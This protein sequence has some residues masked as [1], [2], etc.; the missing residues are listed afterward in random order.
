M[1]KASYRTKRKKRKKKTK[2]N[3]KEV[4]D[5]FRLIKLACKNFGKPIYLMRHL[6][7]DANIISDSIIGKTYNKLRGKKGGSLKHYLPYVPLHKEPS[8]TVWGRKDVMLLPKKYGVT[9]NK[10]DHYT[11]IVS[12]LLRTWIS[13]LLF[14]RALVKEKAFTLT[15]IISPIIEKQG[16]GGNTPLRQSYQRFF[17]EEVRELLEEVTIKFCDNINRKLYTCTLKDVVT[18]GATSN[19]ILIT[20]LY[21]KINKN[22]YY[23]SFTDGG[24][25][26]DE[27]LYMISKSSRNEFKYM[28]E[29]LVYSHN[30]CILNYLYSLGFPKDNVKL[31]GV[32]GY[33]VVFTLH[34]NKIK[35]QIK[36]PKGKN[37]S[38]NQQVNNL[39]SQ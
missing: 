25:L 21:S 32:N 34:N 30:G 31:K 26:L 11:V 36:M 37:I 16:F 19:Q 10:D 9:R 18:Q 2:R 7:T 14:I 1:G 23:K 13:A 22:K 35:V 28:K 17:K 27:T 33:A 3:K 15:L 5:K 39:I 24:M 29:I 4:T 6:N 12:P 20:D 38:F 8:I